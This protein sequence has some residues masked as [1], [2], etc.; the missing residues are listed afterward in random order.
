MMYARVP[1]LI[2]LMTLLALL[3]NAAPTAMPSL[4]ITHNE[5]HESGDILNAHHTQAA[6][7]AEQSAG[8]RDNASNK[9]VS[10]SRFRRRHP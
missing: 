7:V 9:R 10:R 4:D 3:V 5:V 8:K 1:I 6:A 2:M